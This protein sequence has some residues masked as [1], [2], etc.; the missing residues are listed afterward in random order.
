MDYSDFENR[1]IEFILSNL[2]EEERKGYRDGLKIIKQYA[3]QYYSP[4]IILSDGC[5]NLGLP[6]NSTI[7]IKHTVN[8][9]TLQK[10]Y[11]MFLESEFSNNA[12]F[13]FIYKDV[14]T[15][16]FHHDKSITVLT[17]KELFARQKDK[18][19]EFVYIFNYVAR[20]KVSKPLSQEEKF[21]SCKKAFRKGN[22][23]LFIGAGV[24]MDAGLDG[25]GGMLL[26]MK[27]KILQED[28]S[29]KDS[30]IK[31]KDI[32]DVK[33][34]VCYNSTIVEARYLK[35]LSKAKKNEIDYVRE[36]I[37]SKEPKESKLINSIVKLV[38]YK[39]KDKENGN[40]K[41]KRIITYNYDDL[42]EF[43]IS[44]EGYL[45]PQS[46]FDGNDYIDENHFPI[47]H[48]HGIIQNY[49]KAMP[50]MG[51]KIVLSEESYHDLYNQPYSWANVEQ[52]HALRSS[53]CFFIGLSMS[54]PN[55]RRLL[56]VAKRSD[57]AMHYAFLPKTNLTVNLLTTTNKKVVDEMFLE[58]G[59][60]VIWYKDYDELPK[61]LNSLTK[62][63]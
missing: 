15:V 34:D 25:W 10:M 48:V 2:S 27:N 4:D 28:Q 19:K 60:Q 33:K 54:D 9:D 44:K 26:K 43:H 40:S 17:D 35:T 12:H 22:C 29:L 5:N 20:K 61:L 52:M 41:V 13:V 57:G 46:L 49:Y 53:T 3:S 23:T 30:V 39:L 38:Y 7:E 36:I 51:S 18:S 58:L 62:D 1:I 42:L 47:L 6:P 63:N 21:A 14:P 31:N 8:F 11:S 55:L 32:K 37:I 59:V 24:S 50:Y 16:S 56:E 45:K